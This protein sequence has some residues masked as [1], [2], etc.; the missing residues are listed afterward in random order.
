MHY[1][2]WGA[3]LVLAGAACV[4]QA[5]LTLYTDRASWQSAITGEVDLNFEGL[6]PD[7][8][9]TFFPSPPGVTVGGV[10]FQIDPT[11]GPDGNLFAI[12]RGFY[13]NGVSCLSSQGA[14]SGSNGFLVSFP[15]AVTAIGFDVGTFA[16]AGI[17]LITDG[18]QE[19]SIPSTPIY[20]PDPT[21]GT[22]FFGVTSAVPILAVRIDD[23]GNGDLVNLTDFSYGAVPEPASFAVLGLG[24]L[25]FVR[26]RK[27]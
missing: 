17:S 23:P 9:T 4:S 26:R 12:G 3:V 13:Y 11:V 27:R 18:G 21:Q 16:G 1:R 15:G 19:V 25:A 2:R 7:N 6:A 20:N 10:N 5:Q 14:T 22:T 24:V 8:G